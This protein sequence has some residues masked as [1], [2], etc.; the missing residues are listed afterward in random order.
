MRYTYRTRAIGATVSAGALHAQGWGFESLIAHH[1][2]A[3]GSG[4]GAAFG[5]FGETCPR[6]GRGCL[7]PWGRDRCPMAPNNPVPNEDILTG[8]TDP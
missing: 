1:R 7:V 4:N 3:S 2:L 8:K 5:I 6:W